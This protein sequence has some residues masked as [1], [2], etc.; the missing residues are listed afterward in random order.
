MS[1]PRSSSAIPAAIDLDHPV[2]RALTV[3]YDQAM[4]EIDVVNAVRMTTIR[5]RFIDEA[6][7]R[8]VA[9]GAKQLVIL[10]AGLDSHAYR[11]RGL[12]AGVRIFE[13]DRAAMQEMKKRRVRE[14]LGTPPANLTYVE[15]D[16][17]R[18]DVRDVLTSHGYDPRQKTFFIFEGVTMYLPEEAVKRTLRFAAASA[19]GS[20]IVFDFVYQSMI[21]TIAKIDITK[22]PEP[23]KAFVE[24]FLSVTRHEPWV[25]GLPTG[26]E[27]EYLRELGLELREEL[28]L[29]SDAAAARYLTRA[30]GSQVAPRHL[31]RRWLACSKVQEP[32][33]PHRCLP[34]RC[35]RSRESCLI[36]SRRQLCLDEP[37]CRSLADSTY[38]S[39]PDRKRPEGS[40]HRARSSSRAAD[41]SCADR[42]ISRDGRKS[43]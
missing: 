38:R 43:A 36:W 32:R 23:A 27:R 16:L 5:T 42:I 13:V 41:R 29:L 35:E 9:D 10:G 20:G 33:E 18:D 17:L 31:P 19:P 3:G 22:V 24:R 37:D 21:E 12:L 2:V 26:G 39:N 4:K 34:N 8:A 14:V 7:E 28:S 15:A 6:L 11:C 25:F 40:V 30:D 1:W